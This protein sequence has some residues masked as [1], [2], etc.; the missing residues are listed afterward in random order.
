VTSKKSASIPGDKEAALLRIDENRSLIGFALVYGF[1]IYLDTTSGDGVSEVLEK[2]SKFLDGFSHWRHAD[3]MFGKTDMR[4]EAYA[5]ALEGMRSYQAGGSA[6]LSTFLH[7]HVL[8]RMID[9]KRRVSL[10]CQDT[11][12]AEVSAPP[13]MC[14]EDEIDLARELDR[15]GERWSCIMRRIL[16]DGEQIGD[17]AKDEHMSP[18]GL[19][20]ALK[21]R[22]A[23]TKR[24]LVR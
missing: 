14:P 22:L 23:F 21:K 24:R 13:R 2:M 4:Q 12:M 8:N 17:V 5:A 16:V 3:P 10:P 9:L 1:P 15:L 19:T 18:W 11:D 20:R 6:Q 7:K